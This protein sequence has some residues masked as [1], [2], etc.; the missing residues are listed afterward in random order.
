MIKRFDLNRFYDLFNGVDDKS[1]ETA[2]EAFQEAR[3]YLHHHR[4][5]FHSVLGLDSAVHSVD[6]DVLRDNAIHIAEKEGL[7]RQIAELTEKGAVLQGEKE[8][9]TRRIQQDAVIKER[10]QTRL[11][12]AKAREMTWGKRVSSLIFRS[13]VSAVVATGVATL[14]VASEDQELAHQIRVGMDSILAPPLSIENTAKNGNRSF[15]LQNSDKPIFAFV[16]IPYVNAR[17][18]DAINSKIIAP[19]AEGSCVKV[20]G[21]SDKDPNWLR[22]EFSV[23]GHQEAAYMYGR[24]LSFGKPEGMNGCQA[25]EFDN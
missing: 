13:T 2:T 8:E 11:D 14:F 10:L 15:I 20:Y 5:T 4:Q 9:A 22:V 18:D 25:F 24:G 7:K 21:S 19:L 17:K 23:S 16:S 3:D 12:K 1:A 6:D